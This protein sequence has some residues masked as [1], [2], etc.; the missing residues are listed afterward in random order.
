MI[1]QT[2]CVNWAVN[3]ML[4]GP[5][6][7]NTDQSIYSLLADDEGQDMEQGKPVTQLP[8]ANDGQVYGASYAT[9]PPA[10]DILA[11]SVDS[12]MVD[13]DMHKRRWEEPEPQVPIDD[14]YGDL[15]HTMRT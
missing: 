2:S 12:K 7:D 11:T 3:A 4:P 13:D 5:T 6:S 8:V 15:E 1:L 10:A 9:P 14:V